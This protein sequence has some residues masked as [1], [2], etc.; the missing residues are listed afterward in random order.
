MNA[1]ADLHLK[2]GSPAI[3]AGYNVA[4]STDVTA[5]LS[6]QPRI[7]EETVDI[8]VYDYHPLRRPV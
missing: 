2:S 4:I 5:D 7:Q 6:G 1:L 8:G 3:N